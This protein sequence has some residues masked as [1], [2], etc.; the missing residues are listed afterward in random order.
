MKSFNYLILILIVSVNFACTSENTPTQETS[1]LRINFKPSV[2][3]ENLIYSEPYSKNGGEIF[4]VETFKFIISNIVFITSNGDEFVYPQ[5]D[6][7]FLL[8]QRAD[9]YQHIFLSNIEANDYT[10]MRFG[11]GVDQ[12]KYPLNGVD[13]FIPGTQDEGMIWSWS[14]GFIFLKLEGEYSSTTNTIVRPYRYHI[15]S[16]GEN[17]DNY[18]EVYLEF[19][20]PLTI[21]ELVNSEINM[22][23]DVL[24]IFSSEYDMLLEEKDD[25]QIDPENAPK[26]IDNFSKAFEIQ[27]N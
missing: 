19:P 15:G 17:L 8:D 23:F 5:E 21:G 7:Y 9:T 18:R 24:K 14:A 27:M 4:S 10:A 26:I 1:E 12:S 2:G 11:L 25:I 16:H 22:N 3:D 6:S 20:Q 13:N